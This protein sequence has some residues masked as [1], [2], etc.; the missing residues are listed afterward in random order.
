MTASD[1][2]AGKARIRTAAPTRITGI[3]AT[4]ASCA[5]VGARPRARDRSDRCSI[6]LSDFIE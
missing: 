5:C 6:E 4:T 3:P 2:S 1:H